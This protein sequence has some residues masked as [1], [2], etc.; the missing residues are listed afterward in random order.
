MRI[1]GIEREPDSG[2]IHTIDVWYSQR[3]GA[4]IIERLNA[5]GD[6]L[7]AAHVCEHREDAEECLAEWMRS[8]GETHLVAPFDDAHRF[9]VPR[10]A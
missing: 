7:G 10:A 5:D 3:R 2:D 6:C 1:V 8:H 9:A 4:W